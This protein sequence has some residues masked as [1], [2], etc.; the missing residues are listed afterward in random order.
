MQG[1]VKGRVV[2]L[3]FVAVLMLLAARSTVAQQVTYNFMPGVNFSNS[4]KHNFVSLNPLTEI[5]M[6]STFARFAHWAWERA[7]QGE[8]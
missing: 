6:G 8:I 3:A 1:K 5:L 4:K 7:F 2:C